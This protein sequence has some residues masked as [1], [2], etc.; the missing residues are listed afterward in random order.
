MRVSPIP[1]LR[2]AA[3]AYIDVVRNTPLTLVMFFCVF[4]LPYLDIRFGSDG[5]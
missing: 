3:A 2:G 4:G 1:I 5:R